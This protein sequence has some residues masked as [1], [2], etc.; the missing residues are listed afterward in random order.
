M[1]LLPFRTW[2][3]VL[4]SWRPQDTRHKTRRIHLKRGN[5]TKVVCAAEKGD[6]GVKGGG[7]LSLLRFPARPP[8]LFNFSSP[9]TLPLS[10]LNYS[11]PHCHKSTTGCFVRTS[12]GFYLD[13]TISPDVSM[14]FFGFFFLSFSAYSN[15]FTPQWIPYEQSTY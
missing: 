7:E 10:L 14:V 15:S 2:L 13:V 6:G 1:E 12:F 4:W 3:Q 8:G 9:R 5:S 11:L